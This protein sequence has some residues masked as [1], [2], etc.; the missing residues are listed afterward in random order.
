MAAGRR[1]LALQRLCRPER[2]RRTWGFAQDSGP[3][4]AA[5]SFFPRK[6]AAFAQCF[7]IE[8]VL[9]AIAEEESGIGGVADAEFRDRFRVQ[10]AALKILT[11]AGAFGTA[12][13]VLEKCHCALVYLDQ[14]A[15]QLSLFGFAGS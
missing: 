12:Q 1:S 9:E 14:L 6:Q 4:L 8:F 11:G 13:A 5:R 2:S 7:F 3:G 15:A 10:A